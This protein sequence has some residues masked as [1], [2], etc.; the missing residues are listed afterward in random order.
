[1]IIVTG[2]TGFIGSCIVKELNAQGITDIILVDEED[3]SDKK[4]NIKTLRYS[5]FIPKDEFKKLLDSLENIELIIHMGACTSTT[6]Y[7]EGYMLRNNLEY[8]KIIFEW[9]AKNKC[10]MIYASSAAIYGDGSSGY[11]DSESKTK[12]FRPLNIYGGSKKKFDEHALSSKNRPPQWVGLR[13]F[14]VYGP[15]EYHKKAMASMVFHAFNQIKKSGKVRLFKSYD[16]DY[17][18]GG[19]KRDFIYV[20]D[21]VKVVIFMKNNKDISGIFNVGTGTART[22]RDLAIQVFKALNMDPDIEYIDMPENLKV[23]YQYFTKSNI[24]KLRN[25]G[26]RERF[27]SIEEGILDY[28]KNYLN[29]DFKAY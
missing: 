21:I 23:R 15:N 26:Y 22:F 10:R 28:V 7:D 13:F 24:D 3:V 19:Q 27:L 1:M 2:A 4:G 14:N 18:D 6:E 29:E 8:S 17:P 20:K 9:C 12:E 11:D 16:K 5:R 25:A